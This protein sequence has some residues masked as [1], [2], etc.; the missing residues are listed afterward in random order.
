VSKELRTPEKSD[1]WNEEDDM[2]HDEINLENEIFNYFYFVL[3]YNYGDGK[4]D[5]LS[6]TFVGRL[7][8]RVF[9]GIFQSDKKEKE[10]AFLEYLETCRSFSNFYLQFLRFFLLKNI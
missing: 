1:S 7:V 10:R 8:T 3:S 4:F 9:P 6:F 2:Q 5:R